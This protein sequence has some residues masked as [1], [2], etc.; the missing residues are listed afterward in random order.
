MEAVLPDLF[1]SSWYHIV[2]DNVLEKDGITHILTVMKDIDHSERLQ[3]YKRMIIAVNDDPDE[4]LIDFFDSA[5]QWIDDALADGG[6]VM[7]HW[8]INENF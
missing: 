8:Y 1:I 5:I 3:P 4:N 6:K 2:R 7:I